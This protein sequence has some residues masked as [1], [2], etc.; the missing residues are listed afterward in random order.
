VSLAR[1]IVDRIFFPN[2]DVHSIPVLDG[3]FSPNERLDRAR[4]LGDVFDSP[5][6]LV[7]DGEDT[8]YVSAGQTVYACKGRD[9]E[10]R[11]PLVRFEGK[12]GGL[13][14]SEITGLV[15]CV[16]ERGICTVDDAGKIRGWLEEVD[17]EAIRC[18]TA[19]AVASDGTIFVTDG[20]RHNTPDHWLPDLMQKRSPSG[21]LI[22]CDAALTNARVVAEG[23]DWPG[24]VAVT[25]DEKSVYVTESWSHRLREF[26]R[27][28]GKPLAL[29]KNFSG[30]PSRIVRG[31]GG[32]YWLAFFALRTQ[33]TE[34]V[35]R[36]HAFRARMMASVPPN[37]WVGPTLGGAF[38]CREPTQIGRIKK[39][40]IQKPW[41]PPRSYGLV[42]R[43][44]AR[45]HAVESF[46]SRASGQL[47]GVTAV[48][49]D[50]GRVL[51][52]S[53]GHGKIAEL[54]VSDERSA[55]EHDE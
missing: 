22:S 1:D 9:F 7:L 37:L 52:V 2:R 51:V 33:L 27:S 14:W 20:S 47:H 8:L 13:A 18:P 15:V 54:P 41:A 10:M 32:H 45:G 6:A 46:H 42:A 36:E 28:G 11:R 48:A 24:G 39:L 44:D 55:G 43:L 5:D 31:S 19:V 17:G 34:F 25:H 3:G 26:A 50:R 49:D 4:Q 12:A 38:D 16:P 40:G 23:L 30:Y 29:V 53:K 35:L 21:R